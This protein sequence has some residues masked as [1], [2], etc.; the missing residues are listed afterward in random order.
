MEEQKEEQKKLEINMNELRENKIFVA[1][2]MYGGM[3]AGIYT[4]SLIRMQ[5]F[6]DKYGLYMTCSFMFNE[7]LIT[8]ARNSMVRDFLKTDCTHLLFIDADM[9]FNYLDIL[10]ALAF[11]QDVTGIG[12]AKKALNWESVKRA[13]IKDPEIPAEELS[14]VA[15][16]LVFNLLDGETKTDFTA[17]MEVKETGTG[18]MLIKRKVFEDM[19]EAYPQLAHTTGRETQEDS[20]PC[21]AFF[22]AGIDSKDSILGGDSNRYIS[23]DYFFCRLWRKLGGKVFVLPWPVTEHYGSYSF[24][25]D[26]LFMTQKT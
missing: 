9:G 16:K 7:S 20:T 5:N 22:D 12:Y 3:C 4:H 19:I 2:P 24:K 17:P 23:E 15:G 10:A 1:T 14:R 25:G 11:G 21:Y 6:F 13:V 8:R 26:L 18:L